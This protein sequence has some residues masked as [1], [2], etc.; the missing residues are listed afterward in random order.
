MK[1]VY[2]EIPQNEQDL[3]GFQFDDWRV[4]GYKGNGLWECECRCGI[5]RNISSKKLLDDTS[6][7]CNH[8]KR[9]VENLVGRE[10]GEWEVIE[11]AGIK[12]HRHYWLCR[13]SCGTERVLDTFALTS[14]NSKSC[15]HTKIKD[16][17][18]STFGELRVKE[19]VGGGK[20][21]CECSCGRVVDVLGK[22]LRNGDTKTCG[23]Y[24][25]NGELK[26][27]KEKAEA[28]AGDLTGK[29]INEVYVVQYAGKSKYLCECS[30]GNRFYVETHRLAHNKIKNCGHD[31]GK[32]KDMLGYKVNKL[33]VVEY[34]G[35]GMWKCKCE[36]GNYA[37]VR[38]YYLRSK[39][40]VSCGKCHSRL[41]DITGMDFGLLHIEEYI[42]NNRYRC[43]CQCGNVVELLGYNIRKAGNT[44]S[45]GC[46][47]QEKTIKTKINNGVYPNRT[48]E[49]I[50]LAT[51]PEL[52]ES[53]L[54]ELGGDVK[55]GELI[56]I[57][58]ITRAN[59]IRV[60]EKF[61]LSDYINKDYSISEK[62]I[63]LLK[64][65]IDNTD[66]QVIQSDKSVLCGKELDIY[67]P[68]LNLAFEY[69]GTYWH[70]SNIKDKLYHQRK[71][72]ECIEKG[73][74]LIHIFEYE[75]LDNNMQNRLKAFIKDILTQG[76]VMYAKDTK[77]MEVDNYIANKFNS[78]NH[79]Q[80]KANASIN[81]ALFD[82]YNEMVGVMTFGK[83][84]FSRDTQYEL[85]R[86]CYKSGVRVVGGAER[87]FNYFLNKYKPTS[88]ISYCNIAKFN[89]NVYRRLGFIEEG[90]TEPGY[91]WV[92]L[93]NNT[94]LSRYQTQKHRLIKMGLG[95]KDD[96]EDSIMS[97]HRF[98]KIYDSGNIKYK[99]EKQ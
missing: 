51:N 58:G 81:I 15:G 80:G 4:L 35:N 93:N 29:Q 36:C 32:L 62:E 65:I 23:H 28:F 57:M 1:G 20:W 60:I 17:E 84:R 45:C 37:E 70:N 91:V 68:E 48:D 7:I 94:V 26:Y 89:G 33:E 82:E 8:I 10:F 49:Q 47:T 24:Y 14:G 6:K 46:I 27:R 21:R 85:I 53:K 31:S 16:L 40:A 79:L 59:V 78:T 69:N 39:R 38:G 99:W 72:V 71:S 83:P 42:G 77:V 56:S 76:R 75:W 9:K 61:G 86:L 44:A 73:I 30:C 13:C 90:L 18:G 5:T 64:F 63:E 96:T 3:S 98:C 19:Y 95:D 41:I 54:V 55:I 25:V 11:H 88:I 34:A 50:E 43:T 67:I 52:L 74:R 2:T 92:S 87:M 22:S 97:R 66:R 12:N